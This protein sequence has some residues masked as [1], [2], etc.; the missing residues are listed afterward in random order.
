MK[1]GPPP[2]ISALPQRSSS[3]H[4]ELPTSQISSSTAS[5]NAAAPTLP[6]SSF[7]QTQTFYNRTVTQPPAHVHPHHSS[8]S[9]PSSSSLA[10]Y[11]PP[12]PAVAS[13]TA[14]PQPQAPTSLDINELVSSGSFNFFQESQVKPDQ[15]IYMDPAVVSY[16]SIKPDGLMQIHKQDIPPPRGLG[17]GSSSGGHSSHPAHNIPTEAYIN[18]N[19]ASSNTTQPSPAVVSVADMVVPTP[20]GGYVHTSPSIGNYSPPTDSTDSNR[21]PPPLPVQLTTQNSTKEKP[22][23]AAP[24]PNATAPSYSTPAENQSWAD[25]SMA[26]ND[27]D[28]GWGEPD[29]T[30]ENLWDDKPT[31]PSSTMPPMTSWSND[32][33]EPSRSY[34]DS[35]RRYSGNNYGRRGGGGNRD[36]NGGRGGGN[37]SYGGGGGYRGGNRG[38]SYGGGYQNGNRGYGMRRNNSSGD[39][40]RNSSGDGYRNNSGDG[41][42]NNS[43]DGYRNNSGDGYRNSSGDGYRSGQGSSGS[44]RSRGGYNKSPNNAGGYRS[45][46]GGMGS[47]MGGNTYSRSHYQGGQ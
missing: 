14:P 12:T 18:H 8:V 36:G 35:D 45:R 33:H 32:H 9:P 10:S 43:G 19:Y 20:T 41:Y 38:G 13:V 23:I 47:G 42:R 39:G 26:Q 4:Q 11:P 15:S 29:V 30:G 28:D 27:D 16:G 1:D 24:T 5:P 44:Y 40:Y 34:D 46:G 17:E 2:G 22:I 3:A 6:P 7:S 21:R 25:Q 37:R 31:E